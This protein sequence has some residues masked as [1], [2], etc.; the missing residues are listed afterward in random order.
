MSA[1]SHGY[2]GWIHCRAGCMSHAN[3]GMAAVSHAPR[4]TFWF[5]CRKYGCDGARSLAAAAAA[6]A[7]KRNKKGEE[8][9]GGIQTIDNIINVEKGKVKGKGKYDVKKGNFYKGKGTN[10]AR[11]RTGQGQGLG[12]TGPSWDS[13]VR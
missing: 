6:E 7:L 8:S 12:P 2:V 10:R 11:A 4:R 1:A 13:T 5:A 9:A 3:R